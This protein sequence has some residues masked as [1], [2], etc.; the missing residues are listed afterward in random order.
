M[1]IQKKGHQ[2][3]QTHNLMPTTHLKSNVCQ[4]SLCRYYIKIVSDIHGQILLQ[5]VIAWS[6]KTHLNCLHLSRN[7]SSFSMSSKYWNMPCMCHHQ[8]SVFWQIYE[9]AFVKNSWICYCTTCYCAS[10][11]NKPKIFLFTKN[12]CC[13]FFR[14]L[15]F[16]W[17]V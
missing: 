17:L 16:I 9:Q 1:Y 12:I 8:L 13:L 10:R 11:R 14:S 15:V 4:K 7:F 3:M 6:T 2:V 5:E